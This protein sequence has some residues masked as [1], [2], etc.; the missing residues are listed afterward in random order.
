MF[1][2]MRRR[3][4]CSSRRRLPATKTRRAT[5]RTTAPIGSISIRTCRSTATA[6]CSTSARAR[7]CRAATRCSRSMLQGRGPTSL[8]SSAISK[9][10]RSSTNTMSIRLWR[11][12][13]WGRG[14]CCSS[15]SPGL[16]QLDIAA[17][18]IASPRPP[19]TRYFRGEKAAEGV[20]FAFAA[21]HR[22]TR[23]STCRARPSACI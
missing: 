9:E 19:Q 18:V 10:A 15:A 14:P 11:R 20:L 1:P 8:A 6:S 5:A 3:S 12:P 7:R 4:L 2:A 16:R 21:R 23:R 22:A 17:R 13:N